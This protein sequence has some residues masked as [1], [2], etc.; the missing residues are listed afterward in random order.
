MTI[1]LTPDQTAW[2]AAQ[3]AA[4]RFQSIDAAARAIIDERMAIEGDDQDWARPLLDAARD[5][6][7]RG[8]ATSLAEVQQRFAERIGRLQPE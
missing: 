8:E 2:L 5:G 4:G 3:V 1:T 7:A 6:V